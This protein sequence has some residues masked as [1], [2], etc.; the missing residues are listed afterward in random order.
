M[1]ILAAGLGVLGVGVLGSLA[2][3]GER[4]TAEPP[5]LQIEIQAASERGSRFTITNHS[6]KT[7]TACFIEISS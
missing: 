6:G 2:G 5:R 4:Q 1:K 3:Y 7:L